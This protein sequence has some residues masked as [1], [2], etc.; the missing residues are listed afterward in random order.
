MNGQGAKRREWRFTGTH[1]LAA[2]L[3]FFGVIVAVNLTLAYFA[4]G[5][6]TGLV[7][8]NSYVASQQYNEK[9]AEVRRQRNTGWSSRF[10]YGAETAR[11]ELLARDG[12]ALRGF[13]VKTL[14]SRPAHENEDIELIM[15]EA[16]GGYETPVRLAPGVWNVEVTAAAGDRAYR[17]L[18]RLFVKRDGSSP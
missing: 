10:G 2:I 6:W 18:F 14:F 8:K 7:V 1:M 16:D 13:D 9:L 11:F 15:T 4:A 5:T 17:R 12:S 3:S